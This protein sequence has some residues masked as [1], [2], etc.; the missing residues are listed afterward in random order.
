MLS[1]QATSPAIGDRTFTTGFAC[2]IM[3]GGKLFQPTSPADRVAGIN[4][5][6]PQGF[7]EA[8]VSLARAATVA[9]I[10]G[11]FTPTRR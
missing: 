10:G 4:A 1:A 5:V 8:S 6:R 11:L 3:L 7:I 2:L 9:P